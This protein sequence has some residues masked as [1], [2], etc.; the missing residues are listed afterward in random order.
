[1]NLNTKA[2][3]AGCNNEILVSDSGFS[4]GGND[5]VNTSVAREV[6]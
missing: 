6:E 2:R 1:M 4:L 3:T 5:M